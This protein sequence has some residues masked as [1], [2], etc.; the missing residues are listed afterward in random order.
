V[1][2]GI[3]DSSSAAV[4]RITDPYV[5]FWHRFVSPMI[6]A[7]MVGLATGE[8]LWEHQIAPRLDD[9]MGPVFEGVCRSFVRSTDRLPF[10]PLRVGEWWDADS[11]N[12]I[13]VV[14]LGATGS[15]CSGNASGERFG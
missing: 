1:T 7:G 9:Y 8:R 6:S 14:G 3:R 2:N 11:R 4:Y 10:A 12:E 5:A 15:S 13:D